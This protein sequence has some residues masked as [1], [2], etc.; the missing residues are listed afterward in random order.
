MSNGRRSHGEGN[1]TVRGVNTGR[2][3]YDGPTVA[4]G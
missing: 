1:I 4:D 3:R 2:I